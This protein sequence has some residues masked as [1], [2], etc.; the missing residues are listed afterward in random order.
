[1][2]V[3]MTPHRREDG[4]VVGWIVSD[5]DGWRGIDLLGRTVLH[6]DD[7]LAIEAALEDVGIGFLADVWTYDHPGHGPLR[8]RMVEVTPSRIVVATDSF[9]AIDAPTKTFT[10][11]W[12]LPAALR[13][14][15]PGDPEAGWS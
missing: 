11:P 10:L 4:E 6:G 12:P 1:M 8:V 7:W 15:H 9:G 5:G 13:P 3:Q 14:W 2:S